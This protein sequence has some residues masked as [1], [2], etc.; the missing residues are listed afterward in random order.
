[1]PP[2]PPKPPVDVLRL[3]NGDVFL[4]PALWPV[5]LTPEQRVQFARVLLGEECPDAA[6]C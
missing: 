4:L 2:S 5:R 1:M 3:N 6:G